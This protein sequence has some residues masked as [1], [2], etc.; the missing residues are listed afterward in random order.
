MSLVIEAKEL[1]KHYPSQ[2]VNY[3]A[4]DG[5]DLEVASGQLHG[6]VGPDGAGKTT[7]LR[8]L[9][10]VMEPTSGIVRLDGFDVRKQAEQVRARLGYMPQAFS[11]YPDLSVMENLKFFADIKGVPGS[12]QKKRIDELLEFARLKEFTTRRSENLSGGMRK[13]LAL[14]C[15]LIHEP[16]ILLLDEPTTGVDPV[17]RRELWHLLAEV[18][19]QGVT[20][21][22]STPYM[23]ETERCNT[24]S[25]INHGRM[26]I[27]GAPIELEKQMPFQIVEVKARPRRALRA[28][29]DQTDG[30]LSWRAVGDRLRLSVDNPNAV[31]PRID[32]DLKKAGAQI[33]IL[34]EARILMEDVFIYLVEKQKEQA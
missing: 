8:I 31:M 24:V 33:S 6:L 13:K 15:A 32:D 9:A 2:K 26:L 34:R 29:A 20:V 22:V 19:Q 7:L 25:I 5:V 17:S 23:G 3:L 11:L 12:K 18:I 1:S 30:V 14:A 21:L 28:V 10:T 27:T 16:K 4:L